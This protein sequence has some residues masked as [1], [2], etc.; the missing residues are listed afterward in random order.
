MVW[1]PVCFIKD[2][3]NSMWNFSGEKNQIQHIINLRF[4]YIFRTFRPVHL[5]YCTTMPEYSN[6]GLRINVFSRS[7]LCTH[8]LQFT[9]IQAPDGIAN[10]ETDLSHS[11]QMESWLLHG[12]ELNYVRLYIDFVID[13]YSV[14]TF[15]SNV[16]L[17]SV[18]V[19][20]YCRVRLR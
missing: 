17:S 18:D 2:H 9:M 3:V 6:S 19:P 4:R 15:I 10:S 1:I 7:I 12:G 20:G 11:H 16:G 5:L 14:C 13:L 8:N